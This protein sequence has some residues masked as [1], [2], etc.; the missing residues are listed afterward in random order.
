[1]EKKEKKYDPSL[2]EK[3]LELILQNWEQILQIAAE[4][5]P[6]SAYLE[7][8]F[9]AI[10]APKDLEGIG[11]ENGLFPTVFRATKDIPSIL[12]LCAPHCT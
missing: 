11:A 5:L 3:R 7:E 12:I 8:I 1:M 10:G 6:S 2:H 4:E 9:D